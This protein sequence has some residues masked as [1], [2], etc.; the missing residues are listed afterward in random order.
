MK[1][2]TILAILLVPVLALAQTKKP[3]SSQVEELLRRKQQKEAFEKATIE[4]IGKDAVYEALE[5]ER[6]RNIDV[7]RKKIITKEVRYRFKPKTPFL[8]FRP[9]EDMTLW[10][11]TVGYS[12]D[13][14]KT[15]DGTI[16]KDFKESQLHIENQFHYS[17][18]KKILLKYTNTYNVFQT[19]KNEKREVSGAIITPDPDITNGKF[20]DHIFEF[21]YRS[22]REIFYGYDL[23]YIFRVVWPF[24]EASRAYAF[25]TGGESKTSTTTASQDGNL[26]SPFG[27]KPVFGIDYFSGQERSRFNIGGTIGY[28]LSGRY[29]VNKGTGFWSSSP[30]GLIV[31][32]KRYADVNLWFN[33]QKR[34]PILKKTFYGGGINAY[35]TTDQEETILTSGADGLSWF[36]KNK[37]QGY[38]KIQTKF[39]MKYMLKDWE[40]IEGGL[41][42]HIPYSYKIKKEIIDEGAD[43]GGNRTFFNIQETEKVKSRMPIELYFSY[44]LSF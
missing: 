24:G 25:G 3:L 37:T 33:Y 38:F 40:H 8:N 14:Y 20:G 11:S 15:N 39:W 32:T 35:F 9:L 42:A 5:N 43:G 27:A 41:I 7:L 30:N 36:Q 16:K 29:N 21:N 26:K 19:T 10:K 1:S 12:F 23:D 17:W 34:P 44:S 18:T 4:K 22:R 2:W 13:S 28:A 31:K 6:Q